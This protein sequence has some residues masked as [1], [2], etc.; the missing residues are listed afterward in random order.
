MSTRAAIGMRVGDEI[1]TIYSHFDGYPS[2]VGKILQAFHRSEEKAKALIYGPVIRNF[3]HD[4]TCVRYGDGQIDD[5]EVRESPVDA[6]HGYD[7][8]YMWDCDTYEWTC[9]ARDGVVQP[10]VLRRVDIPSKVSA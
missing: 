3:D 6:I 1:H 2:H 10:D 4:G 9:F 8:L 5:H 7:Y